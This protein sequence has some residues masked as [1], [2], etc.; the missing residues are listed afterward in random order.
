[1]RYK[2]ASFVSKKFSKYKGF[3]I[4]TTVFD[5]VLLTF[6]FLFYHKT[7]KNIMSFKTTV[8]NW[9]NVVS[10]RHQFGG[11]QFD[12]NGMEIC[13]IHG[14]GIIDIL[15]K[16]KKERDYLVEKQFCSPHHVHPKSKWTTFFLNSKNLLKDLQYARISY[17]QT[18]KNDSFLNSRNKIEDYLI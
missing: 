13:H 9:D 16:N 11:I 15:W 1:M 17:S 6:T 2:I 8:N 12:I 3:I 10:K 7:F 5:K 14:N 4:L 18:I